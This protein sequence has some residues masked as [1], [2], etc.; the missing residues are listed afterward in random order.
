MHREYCQSGIGVGKSNA[1]YIS[2]RTGPSCSETHVPGYINSEKA[3]N[4]GKI[5]VVSVNDAFVM[6]AWGKDLDA[7]NK[8]GVRIPFRHISFMSSMLMRE[9]HGRG[10]S[11]LCAILATLF[12]SG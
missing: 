5:F 7:E 1:N 12:C 3:K 6:K 10:H 2:H 4:Y 8:S 9:E 11:I